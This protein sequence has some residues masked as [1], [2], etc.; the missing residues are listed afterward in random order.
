M[1]KKI[2][3][4]GLVVCMLVVAIGSATMAYFTDTEGAT[5]VM[6]VGEIDI[7]QTETGADGSEFKDGQH[8][9]P[10]VTIVKKVEVENVGRSDAFVR[11]L[12]AFEGTKDF[13]DS[14]LDVSGDII[15]KEYIG[16]ITVNGE[17]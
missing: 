16:E 10:D 9:L 12:I 11:T 17:T 2:L 1:K 13:V 15:N 14:K 5:N 8:L 7:E 6:V 4:I 3:A